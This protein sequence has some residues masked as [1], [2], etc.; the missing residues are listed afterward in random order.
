MTPSLSLSLPPNLSVCLSLSF[1]ASLLVI[2]LCVRSSYTSYSVPK[3]RLYLLHWNFL[4]LSIKF[5]NDFAFLFNLRFRFYLNS[6]SKASLKLLLLLTLILTTL[7]RPKPVSTF[8]KV[9]AVQRWVQKYLPWSVELRNKYP[10]D[11]FLSLLDRKEPSFR[12]FVSS[13]EKKWEKK[14][15]FYLKSVFDRK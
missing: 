12:T 7:K 9:D 14:N 10:W 5:Q 1:S 8:S 11:K 4:F 15:H 6:L 3:R 13:V 2:L